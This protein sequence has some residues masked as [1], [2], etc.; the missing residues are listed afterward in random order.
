MIK[1]YDKV[2]P[3]RLCEDIRKIINGKNLEVIN[4]GV[5]DGV[6]T[7]DLEETDAP[8][9][10]VEHLAKVMVDEYF[11]NFLPLPYETF[12]EAYTLLRYPENT[13]CKTHCDRE[14]VVNNGQDV[15]RLLNI[16]IFL[17]DDFTEGKLIFEDQKLVVSPAIGN[18]VGFPCSFIVPH[19]VTMVLNGARDALSISVGIKKPTES[20]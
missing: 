19:S 8:F 5:Q 16:I 10:E 15:V 9:K 17:N 18:A 14:W 13:F 11:N 2:F 4:N 1:E 6:L 3:E 7:C 12:V 20:Y